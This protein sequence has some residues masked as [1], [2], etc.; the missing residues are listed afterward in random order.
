MEKYRYGFWKMISKHLN[1]GDYQAT[2]RLAHLLN[3]TCLP[4]WTVPYPIFYLE[5]SSRTTHAGF[6]NEDAEYESVPYPEIQEEDP[7]SNPDGRAKYG[8]EVGHFAE[9]QRK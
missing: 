8:L 7:D 5:S 6:K 3:M 1:R 9:C 4:K 2:S